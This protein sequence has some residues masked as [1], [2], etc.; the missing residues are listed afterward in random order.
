MHMCVREYG[1]VGRVWI[2]V[3]QNQT[4]VDQYRM[5]PITTACVSVHNMALMLTAS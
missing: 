3:N 5:Q 2:Y 4:V 1:N